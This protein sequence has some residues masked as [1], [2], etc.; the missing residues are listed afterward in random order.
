MCQFDHSLRHDGL[1]GDK[2]FFSVLVKEMATRIAHC[3]TVAIVESALM[4]PNAVP[5]ILGLP[6]FLPFMTANLHLDNCETCLAWSHSMA[7]LFLLFGP[8]PVF[9]RIR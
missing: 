5:K 9:A 3:G 1:K 2:C 8:E 6:S 4:D 7:L